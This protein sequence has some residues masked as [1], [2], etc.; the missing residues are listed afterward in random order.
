MDNKFRARAQRSGL[1]AIALATADDRNRNRFSSIPIPIP[2]SI[3]STDK[4]PLEKN[5]RITKKT[6]YWQNSC[7]CSIILRRGIK[8]NYV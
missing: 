8:K 2:I 1:S 6:N 5:A 4:E 7:S 3:A